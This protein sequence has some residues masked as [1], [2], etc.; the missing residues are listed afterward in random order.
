MKKKMSLIAASTLHQNVQ[1]VCVS[2]IEKSYPWLSLAQAWAVCHNGVAAAS[3]RTSMRLFL[4]G[5]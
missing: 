3:S 5:Q 2:L 4:P 1:G